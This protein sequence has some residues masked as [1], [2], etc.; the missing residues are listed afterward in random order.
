MIQE[1]A[2]AHSRGE[3]GFNFQDG[4]VFRLKGKTGVTLRSS[5]HGW[6]KE[7]TT[8][9]Y[10]LKNRDVITATKIATEFLMVCRDSKKHIAGLKDVLD[11][12]DVDLDIAYDVPEVWSGDNKR[13][14]HAV[15]LAVFTVVRTWVEEDKEELK[16]KV[17]LRKYECVKNLPLE[18]C[19]EYL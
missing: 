1:V 8:D 13:F 2:D 16:G 7:G 10:D 11:S 18:V 19:N 15:S 6:T 17:Q 14:C 9:A 4:E 5:E 3:M 12:E